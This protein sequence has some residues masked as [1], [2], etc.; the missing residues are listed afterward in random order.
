MAD[1]HFENGFNGVYCVQDQVLRIGNEGIQPYDMTFGAVASCFYATFLGV[2][3]EHGVT[4]RSAELTLQPETDASKEELEAC[5]KEALGKCSMVA[6]IKAVAQVEAELV[7]P[8]RKQ[9]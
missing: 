8:E 5:M 7:L 9:D 4:V 6:T 2:L 1:I 3:K